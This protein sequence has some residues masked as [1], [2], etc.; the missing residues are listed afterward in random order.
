MLAGYLVA[1]AKLGMP[2]ISSALLVIVALAAGI[3]SSALIALAG[4]VSLDLQTSANTAI[5]GIVAAAIAAGLTRTDNAA[6]AK[7]PDGDYT[8]G[9]RL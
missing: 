3:A 2:N 1:F 4:G 9:R 5:Q 6:E 7:R 8:P